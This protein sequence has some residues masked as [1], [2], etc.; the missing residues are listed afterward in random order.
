MGKQ[1]WD[2]VFF[3]PYVKYTY[4]FDGDIESIEDMELY[5]EPVLV[6]KI[7][8]EDEIAYMKI[9]KVWLLI[10]VFQKRIMKN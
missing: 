2:N 3:N 4:K 8:L 7:L 5:K 10:I 6:T 9:K 1:V